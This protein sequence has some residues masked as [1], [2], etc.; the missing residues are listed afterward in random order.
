MAFEQ[1]PDEIR[2]KVVSLAEEAIQKQ[3]PSSWFDTLYVDADGDTAKIPWA[4]LTIHPYLQAWITEEKI[5]GN[6]SSAL[7]IG[8]G[9]GDDAEALAKL[10]FQVTAFDVSPEAIAWCKKRFPDSEVNYLVADLFALDPAWQGKFCLVVESRTIQA[11]P[12]SVRI[13]AIVAIASLV[14]FV[15]GKLVVITRYRDTEAEPDGPPWALSESELSRF[16]DCGL[17]EVRREE[18]VDEGRGVTEL[19][20]EYLKYPPTCGTGRIQVSSKRQKRRPK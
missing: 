10:G 3:D 18:F 1:Q 19:R 17:N 5:T 8:C 13:E 7:V 6:G 14:T 20:L 12:L 16:H 15:E 4:R 2:Q 11:L 9:L